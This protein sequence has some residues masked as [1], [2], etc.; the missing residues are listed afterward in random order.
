M[1]GLQSCDICIVVA[2][3]IMA[4]EV[5]SD[6]ELSLLQLVERLDVAQLQNKDQDM[7][8]IME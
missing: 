8:Q 1:H 2:Y 3:L 4:V 5:A 7:F 6:F